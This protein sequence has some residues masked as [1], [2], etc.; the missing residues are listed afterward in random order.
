M[1]MQL[2]KHDTHKSEPEEKT[3]KREREMLIFFSFMLRVDIFY[4]LAEVWV[5]L[6][7]TERDF[8]SQHKSFALASMLCLCKFES[9][10]NV[11][12]SVTCESSQRPVFFHRWEEYW[13]WKSCFAVASTK[14]ESKHCFSNER[15]QKLKW[16]DLS[17]TTF[18]G[19]G[20]T[21][22]QSNYKPSLHRKIECSRATNKW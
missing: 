22:N 9:A 1:L 10:L 4:A 8:L 17:W 12:F 3:W 14:K 7:E 6:A 2:L 5:S 15:R 20:E 13:T 16:L 11:F 21:L 18:C 19:T